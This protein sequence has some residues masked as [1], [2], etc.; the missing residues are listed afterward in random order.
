MSSSVDQDTIR[1][2]AADSYP[3]SAG[4]PSASTSCSYLRYAGSG[5]KGVHGSGPPG[6][7]IPG[8]RVVSHHPRGPPTLRMTYG[9]V[10]A[11]NPAA[12]CRRMQTRQPSLEG[13]GEVRLRRLI[14]EALRMR[15]SRLPASW[16]IGKCATR[17]RPVR[18]VRRGRCPRVASAAHRARRV[19]RAAWGNG[20]G[21]VCCIE[22]SP[23]IFAG[24]FTVST[25][26]AHPGP[27][28][29]TSSAPPRDTRRGFRQ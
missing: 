20:P 9:Q 11:A 27:H 18:D 26:P 10:L 25:R 21:G 4:L 15:P 5:H 14:K 1:A 22:R 24:R 7:W 2:T 6:V 16:D 17:T 13:T 28:G 23:V 19:R 3:D 12:G 29:E 8:P